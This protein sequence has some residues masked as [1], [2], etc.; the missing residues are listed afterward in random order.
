MY[1]HL[2]QISIHVSAETR[3]RN[4]PLTLQ[5]FF[6]QQLKTRTF[7]RDRTI[8]KAGKNFLIRPAFRQRSNLQLVN[9]SLF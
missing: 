9:K 6:Q 2:R 5:I 1:P 8:F 4:K 7:I 3:L